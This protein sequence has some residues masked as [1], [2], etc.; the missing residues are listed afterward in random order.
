MTEEE[1]QTWKFEECCEYFYKAFTGKVEDCETIMEEF[2]DFETNDENA[3]FP[4]YGR[5][6][7]FNC[8]DFAIVFKNPDA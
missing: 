2:W 4:N 6:E 5:Y 1:E 8:W 7:D 3:D